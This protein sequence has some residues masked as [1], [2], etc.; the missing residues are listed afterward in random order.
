MTSTAPARLRELPV[1]GGLLRYEDRGEGEAVLLIHAGVFSTWFTPLADSPRLN[2]LRVIR[3]VR[4]GYGDGPAP[5]RTLTPADHAAHCAALIDALGLGRAHVVAHSSGAAVAMQLAVYRPE[6]VSSLVLSEPPMVEG[7]IDPADGEL[8]GAMLGP[9]IEGAVGAAQRGDDAAAFAAFMGAVCGPAHRDVLV[10]AL[11]AA[12][13]E[14]AERESRTFF[15]NELPGVGGWSF[16]D[17][18]AARITQ[19]VLLVQGGASPPPVHRLIARLARLLPAA[20]VATIDGDDHLLP[21]R[22]PDALATLIASFVISGGPA[23]P[24]GEPASRCP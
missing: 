24:S 3:L 11:G 6:L 8:V 1:D 12:A 10:S 23:G 4:A 15:T 2:G 20:E 5:T 9:A 19:P 16:D 7:L 14:S 17:H 13:V 21:L 18:V 22:S